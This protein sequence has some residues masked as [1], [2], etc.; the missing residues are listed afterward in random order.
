MMLPAKIKTKMNNDHEIIQ[1]TWRNF[2]SSPELTLA[3]FCMLELSQFIA[4]M[5]FH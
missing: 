5:Y 4:I 1:M 3:G 2:S